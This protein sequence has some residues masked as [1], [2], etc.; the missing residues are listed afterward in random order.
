TLGDASRLQQIVWNLLANALK[1]T[2]AGGHI[3]V[4][5]RPVDAG[6]E[7]TVRDDGQGIAAETLPHIFDRF[8]QAESSF[9]RSHGGLGLGLAIVRHLVELHGGQVSAESAGL[10]LGATFRVFV[11]C[12]K[13]PVAATSPRRA[14]WLPVASANVLEGLDVLLVDDD[15]DGREVTAL[16]LR[17][18]GARVE[19]VASAS[20]ALATLDR[21]LPDVLLSDLGMP[22][23]DGLSL[24]RKV[25]SRASAGGGSLPAVAMTAYARTEDRAQSLLAGF[26][27]YVTKPVEPADL[28][29]AVAKVSGRAARS[30]A[31]D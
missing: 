29:H 10:G 22:D 8:K 12:M 26:D 3:D 20:Q 17:Q 18:H 15:D 27:A 11:P 23:E 19:T 14:S 25:R 7:L 4:A 24:L 2:P 5:L 6:L 13:S 30:S 21:R 16:L 9:T 1:F 31:R 28:I